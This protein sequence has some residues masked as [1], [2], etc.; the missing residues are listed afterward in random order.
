MLCSDWACTT[1]DTSSVP[2]PSWR[3]GT[4]RKWGGGG[5][6]L[7]FR[8]P[9]T[10]NFAYPRRCGKK[11]KGKKVGTNSNRTAGDEGSGRMEA[12][13]SA[14]PCVFLP[15]P[16]APSR[17]NCLPKPD[18]LGGAAAGA[19][20]VS[21]WGTGGAAVRAVSFHPSP[22]E[23]RNSLKS[24]PSSSPPPSRCALRALS[25]TLRNF[26]RSWSHRIGP[27]SRPL[28]RLGLS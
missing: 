26:S 22:S 28:S 2:R 19:G 20:G 14:Y 21:F 25:C 5:T 7:L 24:G 13:K 1:A 12:D 27:S 17:P 23:R 8:G 18:F 3:A 10:A 15:L 11:K 4:K 9:P 16:T 6:C